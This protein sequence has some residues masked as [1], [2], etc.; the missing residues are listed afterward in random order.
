MKI[1]ITKTIQYRY[2]QYKFK[3]G[4]LKNEALEM[5]SQED[6]DKICIEA[7]KKIRSFTFIYIPFYIAVIFIFHFGFIMNPEYSNNGFVIWYRGVIESVIPLINGNWGST[8]K[9]KQGT[10][11]IIYIKLFPAIVIIGLPLFIPILIMANRFLI[12]VIEQIIS[13]RGIE[14][15]KE[16]NSRK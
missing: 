16:L 7:T 6:K 9:Q 2:I 4:C 13:K 11:L 12:Q 15:K 10:F 3:K 5:L 14:E 1:D 8:W